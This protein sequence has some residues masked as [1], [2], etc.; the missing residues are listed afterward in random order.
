MTSRP[1]KAAKTSSKSSPTSKS[2][3]KF[4]NKSENEIASTFKLDTTAEKG[5]VVGVGPEV[6]AVVCSVLKA[7]ENGKNPFVAIYPYDCV[8]PGSEGSCTK[9]VN[10]SSE[11]VSMPGKI[12]VKG[13]K[14]SEREDIQVD[15]TLRTDISMSF[16]SK[17]NSITY[18]EP[19]SSIILCGL[20]GSMVAGENT[21]CYYNV[22]Y[23]RKDEHFKYDNMLLDNIKNPV[24]FD[25]HINKMVSVV[26]V[27]QDQTDIV[28]SAGDNFQLGAISNATYHEGEM[29]ADGNNKDFFRLTMEVCTQMESQTNTVFD[30]INIYRR[31]FTHGF[32]ITSP[33]LIE[34]IGTQ[35]LSRSRMIVS[36][37]LKS[38]NTQ[39]D[40]VEN[41]RGML[42]V[43]RIVSN[44][45]EI[46]TTCGVPIS[47]A[48]A[49]T[50]YS[51]DKCNPNM[52]MD[53]N[54]ILLNECA[55][56]TKISELFKRSNYKFYAVSNID[57]QDEMKNDNVETPSGDYDSVLVQYEKK[58]TVYAIYAVKI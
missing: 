51:N 7:G 5:T 24:S 48:F 33:K 52:T 8:N 14:W 38:Y 11:I 37:E 4:I 6:R 43:N 45:H 28:E 39:D 21:N 55:Y 19:G 41:A 26:V 15:M 18:L 58:N 57:L 3:F 1:S 2:M 23:I 40:D 27:P 42:Y 17:Y 10:G 16:P 20:N 47:S 9:P 30:R 31:I 49:R 22:K 36:G 54:V 13:S 32:D 12:G 46:V 34:N 56:P 25:M 50:K 53:R 35:L 44:L 29:G